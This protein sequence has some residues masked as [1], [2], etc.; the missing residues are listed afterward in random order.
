MSPAASATGRARAAAPDRTDRP[1]QG[2][3]WEEGSGEVPCLLPALSLG[4]ITLAP[5]LY[6]LFLHPGEGA[7]L[8]LRDF[9]PRSFSR[10]V[11][12]QADA[13]PGESVNKVISNAKR[14]LEEFVSRLHPPRREGGEIHHPHRHPRH[15]R[16]RP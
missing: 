16:L 13:R 7:G 8:Y 2:H 15:D 12:D 5:L 10:R 3:R 6:T 4:G 14:K 11:D 1:A 9:L